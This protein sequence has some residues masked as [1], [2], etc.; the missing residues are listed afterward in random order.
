M[1]PRT[2]VVLVWIPSHVGIP[3]NEKLDEL[4][5]L[6]LNKE[7]YDDKQVIWSDVKIKVNTHLEQLWQTDW[8]T[9]VDNKLH[10]IRPNLKERL[11][12]DERSNRKQ[13]T[14]V[15]RLR[16]G[17]SWIT[18]E[19][20]LKGEQQP[21]CTA[22]ECPLTVKDI[23]VECADFLLSRQKYYKTTNMHTLFREVKAS[24]ISEY[25]KEI[26]LYDKI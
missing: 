11:Y 2:K 20:P 16:I 15:S 4:A 8:D 7:V 21:Y 26:G 1:A 18:H 14:V 24:Q 22:C 9:E 3:G 19:Y 13:E 12:Y 5:K 23:L 17:H 25:L 6:A 10:E